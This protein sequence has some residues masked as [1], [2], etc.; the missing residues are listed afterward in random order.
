M[1]DTC[2]K[3]VYG[4]VAGPIVRQL[5]EGIRRGDLKPGQCIGSEVQLA[6]NNG[7]SR[8]TVRRALSRLVDQG[9][10]ERRPG[11]GLYVRAEKEEVVVDC[12]VPSLAHEQ[13]VKVV[14]GANRVDA[15]QALRLRI[16]DAHGRTEDHV[17]YLRQLVESD[18]DGA[19][20][21]WLQHPSFAEEIYRLKQVGFPFVLVDASL[22]H[23]PVSSVAADH[24]A[25]GYAVGTE[26]V[27]LGHRRIAFVGDPRFQSLRLRLEGLRDAIADA[28]IPFQRDLV[29]DLH[30]DDPLSDWSEAIARVTRELMGRANRPTAIF[31]ANDAA[32]IHGCRVLREMGLSI[33]GDVSVVGFDNDAVASLMVPPLATVEQPSEQLGLKA[34]DMLLQQV[35]SRRR[36]HDV[37]QA[38]E[39]V[40]PIRWI[41]RESAGPAPVGQDKSHAE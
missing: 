11:K 1:N 23:L 37:G 9:L 32:A 7:I 36:G 27:K 8:M 12:F 34:I 26:L 40:L 18:A 13:W 2:Y 35:Q 33:P 24:S 29:A 21:G 39:C 15:S 25:G 10:I 20:I 14:R 16:H 6:E 4:G 28:G 19:I 31:Y 30:I 41:A 22:D 17:G 3:H 5:V 38:I